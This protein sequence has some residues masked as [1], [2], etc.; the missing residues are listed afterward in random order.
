MTASIWFLLTGAVLLFMAITAARLERMPLSTAFVYLAIG[1]VLGPTVA[2]QFH[3]N[4]LEHSGV[5]EVFT[6]IAVLISLFGAGLKLAAPVG[7]RIWWTPFRLATVS[8][9]VTVGLVTLAGMWLL[10]LPLGAAVLL[11]AI[12]APTDPVLATEIQVRGT[13]DDD[14]VRF[15]LTGEAGLND[16]TAFPMVMLGLGLLGLHELGE[17]FAHWWLLDVAWATACGLGVGGALGAATAWLMH[18]LALRGM[19]TAFTE[20]FAGLGLI[21]LSYGLSLLLY[22]YGFLAV[23]AAAFMLHR[24]EARLGPLDTLDPLDPLGEEAKQA[25]THDA[26]RSAPRSEFAQLFSATLPLLARAMA[27]PKAD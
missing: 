5:L 15:A 23:F 1:M 8:M 18:R 11:G 26:H 20:N 7:H 2:N 12:L 3:F 16:G 10:D 14:R 25:P 9:V 24:T 19:H 21:A 17:H 27:M 4:P 22:G 6:E 13:H